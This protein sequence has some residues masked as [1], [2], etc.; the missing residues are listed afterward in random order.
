MTTQP[1]D[2][3]VFVTMTYEYNF[4]V[5]ASMPGEYR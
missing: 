1:H 3:N 4:D 5:V 2:N